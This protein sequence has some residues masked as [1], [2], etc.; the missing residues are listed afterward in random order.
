MRVPS[1]PSRRRRPVRPFGRKRRVVVAVVAVGL[2]V[3]LLTARGVAH[4]YTQALWFSS[5]G[6][7]GVFSTMVRV[8][9]VLALL[10]SL[11]AGTLL[12]STMVVAD[13][14]APFELRP[15][16]EEQLVDRYRLLMVRRGG[17]IKGL[18]ATAFGLLAGVPVAGEWQR[19]LLFTHAQ[20]FATVEPQFK[21]DVGFY[22]FRLP[23]ITF[24][25][26]WT[27]TV[28][29][30]AT[31][32]TTVVHYL[33]GGIRI[34][35][36]VRHLSSL[37]K[38]HLS[39]MLAVLALLK[40]VAYWFERYTLV[41]SKRGYVDGA[42]YTDVHAQLPATLLLLLISLVAAI[43]LVAT[44]NHRDWHLPSI[45]VG[46]WLVVSIV[47]GVLYPAAVQRLRV[48]SDEAAKESTYIARNITATRNALGLDKVET[49]PYP[50]DNQ[51]TATGVSAGAAQLANARLLDPKISASS[52]NRLEGR[53]GDFKFN[54]LDV[55]RYKV[56]D[57]VEQVVIGAR[58]LDPNARR[59]NSWVNRHLVYT[60]GLGV[61][62]APAS[63]I[64]DAGRPAF[65]DSSETAGG[66][67][68]VKQPR[69]YI[70]ENLGS[71]AVV[72][73]T[74]TEAD[75]GGATSPP[76]AAD[77]GGVQ[78]SSRLRRAAFA[79]RF[80][81]WNL[82]APGPI[83]PSS[84]ILYVRDVRERL[85]TLAPFLATDADPYPVVLDGRIVW[86]VDGYTTTDRYPNAQRA[87]TSGLP[88]GSGLLRPFNYVRNSVK[89]V[90]DAY[91]GSVTLYVVDDTDP[92][93]RAWRSIFPALF[94]GQADIPPA[95][96]AHFRYPEDMFRVQSK[97][98]GTYRL[99]E[100]QAFYYKNDSWDVSQR[101]TRVQD[102]NAASGSP[103]VTTTLPPQV[104]ADPTRAKDDGRI[105]PYY[106]L[107]K[108]PEGGPTRFVLLRPFA[109]FSKSDSRVQIAA[110]MT[111]SSESGAP[112]K[113]RVYDIP[114]GTRP[115]GPV[116]VA[117]EV[118]RAFADELTLKDS[119]GSQVVFGD[120]QL[121]PVDH[122]IVW[123]RP[124]YVQETGPGPLPELR[125]VTVTVAHRSA[126]GSSLEEA[127]RKLF[128]VD[129]GFS[130]VVP[131][132]GGVVTNGAGAS[133]STTAPSTTN[134]TRPLASTVDPEALLA[135]AKQAYDAAASALRAGNL[136]EYQAKMREAY[137]SA[138]QAATAALDQNVTAGPGG[139]AAGSATTSTRVSPPAGSSS[140]SAPST[141]TTVPPTT[142]TA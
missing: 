90:V 62:V 82:F 7:S 66:A 138:A 38:V 106:T 72:N 132:L 135:K 136:G 55:D 96:Q 28:L 118:S 100:P 94:R 6:R 42:A 15:G 117:T 57:Q 142:I 13:R 125:T 30:I 128:S 12:F 101:P 4:F 114:V 64:S 133:P 53:A 16:P 130:T 112:P 78:L 67:L 17:L 68:A 65:L 31:V 10:F 56:G 120:L 105:D 126:S 97:M 69:I 61:A 23:M 19:W 129:P 141:S 99:S 26:D 24:V 14:L 35:A 116:A 32:L 9:V 122:S 41:W 127:L 102:R 3:L 108:P 93:V 115:D 8:K 75:G 46:S 50:V 59:S 43:V 89:A 109:P 123:V 91:D 81:E 80:G 76:Y 45:V 60:H 27:F 52:F 104:A 121:M 87:D 113:L 95:L 44:V 92:I 39:V 137:E 110:F 29:V 131:G 85:A 139:G 40:A 119:A 20:S 86:V 70:G 47:A 34:G 25:I 84:K 11:V 54:E 58:E 5:L 71:Y 83:T 1:E 88:R 33:N 21:R 2:L 140:S 98:W 107:L 48:T 73:T 79:L 36:T 51:L 37:A 103:A 111:A 22:V 77:G 49:V 124:W 18:V 74:Q 134:T 63:K